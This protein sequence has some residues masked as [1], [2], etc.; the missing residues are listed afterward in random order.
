LR[1]L[2]GGPDVLKEQK[3]I[4]TSASRDPNADRIV[5]VGAAQDIPPGLLAFW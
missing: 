1:E 4:V 2:G 3:V 5:P